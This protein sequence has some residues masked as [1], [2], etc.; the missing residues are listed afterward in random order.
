M[1]IGKSISLS[2]LRTG[3][4]E[5]TAL[6]VENSCGITLSRRSSWVEFEDGLIDNNY[7][8]STIPFFYLL[9]GY[10]FFKRTRWTNH[11]DV[12]PTT[13]L[14]YDCY[15]ELVD[16]L[17]EN[18]TSYNGFL[19]L[20][21]G[22]AKS[23]NTVFRN[24]S[25]IRRTFEIGGSWEFHNC[26]F[27]GL[28]PQDEDYR[29]FQLNRG[30]R[31]SVFDSEFITN[32]GTIY[33]LDGS[34]FKGT[35]TI[36]RDNP[37][38]V[39]INEGKLVTKNSTFKNNHD[40]VAGGAIWQIKGQLDVFDT[41]FDGNSAGSDGGA[42]YIDATSEVIIVEFNNTFINNRALRGGAIFSYNEG[43]LLSLD[44]STGSVLENNIAEW[45]GNEVATFLDRIV[46]VKP[47]KPIEIFSG[48]DIPAFEV[49][50]YDR[51]GQLFVPLF[52]KM[53]FIAANW[54]T[55]D[56]GAIA[57]TLNQPLITQNVS[58]SEL[59]LFGKP[60]QY[61]ISLASGSPAYDSLVYKDTIPIII[62]EC[63]AGREEVY[64]EN[65]RFKSC[66]VSSCTKGCNLK[67]GYCE[68]NF[69]HCSAGWDGVDCSSKIGNRDSLSIS[70]NESL[71]DFPEVYRERDNLIVKVAHIL[72]VPTER[73]EFRSLDEQ[74]ETTLRF[75]LL[76]AAMKYVEGP[77]LLKQMAKLQSSPISDIAKV[78]TVFSPTQHIKLTDFGIAII[79]AITALCVLVSV[80][81]LVNLIIHRNTREVR[82][83]SPVFAC[84]I[85]TSVTGAYALIFLDAVH[86]TI[87]VCN[88]QVW[89]GGI[90]FVLAFGSI[91]GKN[92]RI[93]RIFSN[94]G[95]V[96]TITD[97]HIF[98]II[99]VL[100]LIELFI[101]S[102]W[103][104]FVPLSPMLMDIDGERWWYC[105][106]D[107]PGSSIMTA[108]ATAYKGTLL[109]CS[110]LIAYKTRHAGQSFSE[111][112]ALTITTYATLTCALIVVPI[113]LLPSTSPKAAFYLKSLGLLVT[114]GVCLTALFLLRVRQLRSIPGSTAKSKWDTATGVLKSKI[115]KIPSGAIPGAFSG[116]SSE[117]TGS[118]NG[119]G[120]GS[121][122]SRLGPLP[123]EG[124]LLGVKRRES[125]R[126]DVRSYTCKLLVG[127]VFGDK[128]V[129]HKLVLDL[130]NQ[131]TSLMR[132]YSNQGLSYRLSA[133]SGVTNDPESLTVN[134]TFGSQF[135]A[136]RF[137]DEKSYQEMCDVFGEM[138][139]RYEKIAEARQVR[140]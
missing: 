73:V 128:W 46:A 18:I 92:Y 49:A 130:R 38:G 33:I 30:G 59:K 10:F 14:M 84:I 86:P 36:F 24:V 7:Y 134:L 138:L 127:S 72:G 37:T 77:A 121:G 34:E 108:V 47:S 88:A 65:L 123:N 83:L 80:W 67:N 13:T 56:R 54:T 87:P 81:T 39:I 111:T 122:H 136:V 107:H 1:S 2:C 23:V 3:I 85:V 94:T 91:I 57:G 63:G 4:N 113:S 26:L 70:L 109:L 96:L 140:S 98:R 125:I 97:M 43:P 104:A 71:Y 64:D 28:A 99:G 9:D 137:R 116:L 126:T 124:N 74:C 66:V 114:N 27:E 42:L 101:D 19:T 139:M 12:K 103:T 55:T 78:Q 90:C 25:S 11:V 15:F 93:Y 20:N 61:N 129:E 51:Y 17:L 76:D 44:C 5:Y 75:S 29:I 120:S 35:G 79:M 6:T 117:E 89:V 8:L 115:G 52:T 58:F 105:G 112:R 32:F 110:V 100:L 45:Q 31:V 53:L 62:K 21:S 135:V 119:K 106:S 16:C 102:L 48:Q 68:L 82:A 133:V 95:R 132:K 118:A 22:T 60:G 40:P 69:C 41:I 131:V 50:A